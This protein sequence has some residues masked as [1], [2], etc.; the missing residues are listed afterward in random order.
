MAKCIVDKRA[1][2]SIV[3]AVYEKFSPWIDITSSVEIAKA[4]LEGY[5][6]MQAAF[7]LVVRNVFGEPALQEFFGEIRDEVLYQELR[8]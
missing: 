2:T 4:A 7:P 6:V 8:V 5:E 1:F 3:N